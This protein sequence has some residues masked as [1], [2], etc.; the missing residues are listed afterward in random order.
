MNGKVRGR[1]YAT[2]I[3]PK[4]AEKLKSAGFPLTLNLLEHS[5]EV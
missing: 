2:G 3:V 5:V 1:F 4:F